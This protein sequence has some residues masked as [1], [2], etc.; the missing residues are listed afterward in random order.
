MSGDNQALNFIYLLGCLILVGSA[1]AVRRIPL[2][3]SI[4]MALA[5][6]L[7][8]VAAFAAFTLKDDFLD[9]GR[10]VVAEGRGTPVMA[11]QGGTVRIRQ[12]TDGHYWVDA[13]VNGATVRFL[14]DSG[15]TVTSLS[16]ATARAAGVQ[17]S[18]AM[19]ERVSTGNGTI[20]VR[21]A[22][23]AELRLGPITRRDFRVQIHDNGGDRLNVLGMN[24]LSSLSSWGV[25]QRWL[26]LKP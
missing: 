7:I 10:R 25:D 19:P 23:I 1:V 15:A 21:P 12:S 24:F 20:L 14:V 11:E 4:K 5:W 9:L 18:D 3:S 17:L 8:F 2:K 13:Q 16:A 22:R 26:I 6:V